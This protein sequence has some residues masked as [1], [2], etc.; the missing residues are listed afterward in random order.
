MTEGR[1]A[2]FNVAVLPSS[3]RL[4]DILP[5]R[6]SRAANRLAVGDLRAP[7]I[8]AHTKFPLHAVHQNLKM[9][10][11]HAGNEGLAGV[12]IRMDLESWILLGKLAQ[13]QTHFL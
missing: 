9:Q 4:F 1:D 11:A 2:D 7:H 3:P 5:L 13:R 10:F 6:L 8:G 12:R